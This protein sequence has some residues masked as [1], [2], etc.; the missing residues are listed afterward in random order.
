M[1][2]EP[3][4][5]RRPDDH[6]RESWGKANEFGAPDGIKFHPW[7]DDRDMPTH[8]MP[9][10]EA[11]KCAELQGGEAFLKYHEALLKLYFED[12][13]D[14]SDPK[15]LVKLAKQVGLDVKRFK[16]DLESGSQ[17]A[18]ILADLA[19]AQQ[20]KIQG[21]P[22]AIFLDKQGAIRIVGE[23]KLEQYKRVVDWLLAT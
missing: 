8:S 11:G 1:R 5:G 19:E 21:I 9:A 18:A 2:I 10:L 16:K 12:N 23:V 14:I 7:P 3:T 6:S 22:T 13:E 15:V 17:R 4:K 20:K